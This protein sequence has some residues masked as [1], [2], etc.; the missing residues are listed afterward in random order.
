MLS[1]DPREGLVHHRDHGPRP[2]AGVRCA[3]LPKAA[4]GPSAFAVAWQDLPRPRGPDA[5]HCWLDYYQGQGLA[6]LVGHTQGGTRRR[7]SSLKPS[8]NWR[9][10]LFSSCFG[11]VWQRSRIGC[12]FGFW[13]GWLRGGRFWPQV[14]GGGRPFFGGGKMPGS[15]TLI[16]RLHG[17]DIREQATAAQ[18]LV[19]KK[20]VPE[21]LFPPAFVHYCRLFDF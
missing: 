12:P 19:P 14:S 8:E 3:A 20:G 9:N 6:G 4:G 1:G 5:A 11:R 2:A 7:Y 16:R 15:C 17:P 10:P 13:R 18:G 21:T